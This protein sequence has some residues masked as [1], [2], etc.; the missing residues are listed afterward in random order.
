MS[1]KNNTAP[2]KVGDKVVVMDPG[3]LMLQKFAPKGAKPNN[4]GIVSEIWEDGDILVEFP[5]KGKG[6]SQVAPYPKHLVFP[7]NKQP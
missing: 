7:L 5:L 3:L 1:N 6:H 4:V 2:L